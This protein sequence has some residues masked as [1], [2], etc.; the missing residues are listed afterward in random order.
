[1][2]RERLPEILFRFD[3]L[4]EASRANKRLSVRAYQFQIQAG[5]SS[6]LPGGPQ[7]DHS[8]LRANPRAWERAKL[9]G[10]GD[11]F[12]FQLLLVGWADPSDV[13]DRH[14]AQ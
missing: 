10:A 3:P 13:P 12:L 5:Q 8:H 4:A 11:A 2:L 6:K 1:M 7:P 14:A 9:R